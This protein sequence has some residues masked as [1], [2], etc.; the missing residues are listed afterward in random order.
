MF[1]SAPFL[2]GKP[3]SPL[4]AGKCCSNQ[5]SAGFNGFQTNEGVF[6]DNCQFTS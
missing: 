4:L 2:R 6:S 5:V 3:G 1:G